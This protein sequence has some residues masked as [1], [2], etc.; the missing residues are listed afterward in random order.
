MDPE[1][2]TISRTAVKKVKI[3]RED[4]QK[5]Q[6]VAKQ[7]ELQHYNDKMVEI[8]SKAE[9]MFEHMKEINNILTKKQGKIED[10]VTR[11]EEI[12]IEE[13]QTLMT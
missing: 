7:A 2:Q 9:V 5:Q 6:L 13:L 12:F 11:A 1:R 4:S 8:N 3:S 10:S